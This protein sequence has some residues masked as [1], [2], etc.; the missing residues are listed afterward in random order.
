M[1]V[2]EYEKFGMILDPTVVA[3]MN[4]QTVQQYSQQPV[5]SL[6]WYRTSIEVIPST[7]RR[8]KY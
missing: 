2:L 7:G 8:N 6:S 5:H 3:P 4:L 1:L